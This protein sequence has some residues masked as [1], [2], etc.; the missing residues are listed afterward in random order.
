MKTNFLPTAILAGL[1]TT[2]AAAQL[3]SP[4]TPTRDRGFSVYEELNGTIIAHSPNGTWAF[5]SWSEYINSDFFR[6]H[7]VKCGSPELPYYTDDPL[8]EASTS[9]CSSSQTNTNAEYAPNSLYRIPVV[10]HIFMNTSGAGQITDAKV[11]SQIDILNEDFLAL[12]GSNGAPGTDTQIEFYLATEDPNGAPST[13]ITRHT[14]NDWYNDVGAYY[15]S[16][17]WDTNRYL[18]IYTNTASGNLGYAYVPSSGGV[19]GASWDGVRIL[20]SSFGANAPIGPPYNLGRTTTHEVGH[21]L[22]LYHTFDGGCQGGPCHKRGDLICDTNKENSPNFST[23]VRTSCN[24]LDPTHNYMDYSD[25]ICMYEF[26]PDQTYRMR[27]TLAAWRVDLAD[28]VLSLPGQAGNPSPANGA[29]NA[30]TSAGLSWSA[31][32][33]AASYDVYFGTSTSPGF[34]GSQSGTSFDPGALAESTTYYW[35]VDSVNG[36]GTTTGN[37]WSFTTGSGSTG[38][39]LM[40]D[41]FEDGNLNGWLLSGN[42]SATGGAANTG[43]YGA[44]MRRSASME[45][46]VSSAGASGVRLLY[47]RRTS[48]LDNGEALTVEWY[49]GSSWQTVES[50]SSGSWASRDIA[51]GAGADNN[52]ALRIRFSV[53]ANK[54]NERAY[55]DNVSVTSN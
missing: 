11:Q 38:G 1:T 14:N 12:A 30:S 42:V 48:G 17:G 52:S 3:Q 25:D 15:N 28:S 46:A 24:S 16:V 21:Y 49:D 9:D 18:N 13:G 27:C 43:A 22:G 34:Q 41:D 54:N 50:T 35:R 4:Q 6:T 47:D 32:S 53:N 10:V 5:N 29:T 2:L 33:G 55:V 51:L 37:D 45:R 19:V 7:N 44:Q 39:T 40:S 31:G 8:P 20:W 23:C 36:A 26:T